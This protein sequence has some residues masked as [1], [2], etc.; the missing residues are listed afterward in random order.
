M[1][2]S[3][4][5]TSS[6]GLPIEPITLLIGLVRRWK[7]LVGAIIVGLVLGGVAA[8]T[9]GSQTFETETILLYK[10]PDKKDDAGGRSPS[11]SNRVLM[12]KIPSNLRQVSE[13]LELGLPPQK[14]ADAFQVR[15]EKRTSLV[16]ITARWNSAKMASKLA[17][18]LRD[19][20]VASQTALIKA[21][22]KQEMENLDVRFQE[23]DGEL[24]T[25]ENKLQTF[26]SENKIVDLAKEI[27]GNVDQ[28]SSMEL[29]VAN[30]QNDE[31]TIK[32]QKQS[33][34]E[35]IEG[36]K[37]KIDEEQAATTKGKSLADLNI[38][39]ERLRRAIHDDKVQ[40]KNIVELG[41][42]QGSY[43]MAK[44]LFEKGLI[45]EKDFEKAKA[46]YEAKEVDAIDTDEIREWKRQLKILEG[47]VIPEKESFKSPAQELFNSLQLKILDMELQEVS[48]KKKVEYVN[49]QILRVKAKLEVLSGLQR[50][51][52]SLAKEV[53][54]G[55]AQKADL[56]KLLGRVRNIYESTDSG[57][58]LVSDA[59]VPLQSI[60]SNR[61][62]FFGAVAFLGIMI[63]CIVILVSELLDTTIKSAAE[64][65]NK[66]SKTVIG[67]I[68]NIKNPQG[69][70][71]ETSDFPLIEMFRIIAL[72]VRREIP[73]R[74]ARIM[75]TS[76]GRWE[77]K[78]LVTA[79]LAACLGRQDER[80]LVID[81]QVRPVQSE[82]D[83]RY[84]IAE[85]D[86]PLKGLGEWLSFDAL[87]SEEIVWPTLL[88]GVECIPR[89][90]SAVTPDL[91]GSNRMKELM[92]ALSESFSLILIDGP[93]IENYVDAE[94]VSRW[95][96]AIIF[97]VRCRACA[98]STLKRSV[99]RIRGTETPLIGFILNDVDQFYL[100]WA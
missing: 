44:E 66:F 63:G 34:Q 6:P 90:E 33:L 93:P 82:T 49:N 16:I 22:A 38:R 37:T 20:F 8:F 61:K 26:I 17:N 13:K 70:M 40:R 72:S 91:L 23:T 98:S 18:T 87:T 9:L 41:K 54:A 65:Q 43:F 7:I 80:I 15:V 53:S 81:A 79:N 57:F 56:D 59:P 73:Q 21:D 11:V 46:E 30:S 36:L 60:K 28:I 5:Q 89:V 62:I 100:K 4:D 97:V 84:M 32:I 95:C 31:D 96:D 94:L 51:Y 88:A 52:A 47:E 48:L 86:K 77:G 29:L 78:T 10:E 58:V 42:D 3:D 27:Q 45:P 74:G 75:I 35:R 92:D 67:V 24:K 55:E 99:E 64:L 50:Q 1:T 2:T 19:V 83:L 69:L 71:P 68:P 14:L 39:I 25:A 85:K 12:I 76:A